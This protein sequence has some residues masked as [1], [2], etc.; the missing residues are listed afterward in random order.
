MRIKFLVHSLI[1]L[2]P[3][4]ILGAGCKKGK[5]D[6]APKD[7]DGNIYHT[8]TIGSQVWMVENLKVTHYRNGDPLS[9]VLN[10]TAWVNLITGAYCDYNN[11][12]N[13]T[14]T[15]G[16]LYNWYA[17]HDPRNIAPAGWHIPSDAEWTT[18][19]NSWGGAS[20]A[21]GKL[22]EAGTTHWYSPNGGATNESGFT[23]LP[24]GDRHSLNGGFENVTKSALWWSATEYDNGQAWY[25]ALNNMNGAAY[26]SQFSKKIGFSVRCVKD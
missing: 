9:N 24:A 22:K 16:E 2:V 7:I 21:G 3:V 6:A 1:I 13:Y 11:N 5:T 14:T 19:L 15:Y 23:G 8:V 20:A 4:L 17:I 12:S 25:Y 18:L 10:D 26:R